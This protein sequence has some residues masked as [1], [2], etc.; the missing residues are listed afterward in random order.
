MY[1]EG[2]VCS[3]WP[4]SGIGVG[5]IT[6]VSSPTTWIVGIASGGVG[7]GVGIGSWFPGIFSVKALASISASIVFVWNRFI[8][9]TEC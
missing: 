9:S 3:V 5:S 7:V 4:G 2:T 6:L 8:L 1:L